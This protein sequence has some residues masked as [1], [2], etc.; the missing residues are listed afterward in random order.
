[1]HQLGMLGIAV[2]KLLRCDLQI[3]ADGKELLHRRERFTQRDVVMICATDIVQLRNICYCNDR[4]LRLQKSKRERARNMFDSV[5]EKLKSFAKVNFICV[6]IVAVICFFQFI[7]EAMEYQDG[8][9]AF[10]LFIAYG[11]IVYVLLATC[12]FMYAFAEITESTKKTNEAMRM[13]FSRSIYE[14]EQKKR[15]AEEA[16][17]AYEYQQQVKALEEQRRRETEEAEIKR[18]KEESRKAYWAA[19]IEEKN[20]LIAKRDEAEEALRSIGVLATN[21]RKTLQNLID[22]INEE[23]TKDR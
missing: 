7:L 10:L 23:L 22:S 4:K 20:A 14:E 1:M 19:H 9:V 12:W 6:V 2:E 16:R 15:E 8:I 21:E 3:I 11:L 17:K 5:E 13:A 18:Q